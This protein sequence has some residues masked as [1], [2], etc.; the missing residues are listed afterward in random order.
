MNPQEW[1]PISFDDLTG[2]LH[3]FSLFRVL[4][5]AYT[6]NFLFSLY[7]IKFHYHILLK[8]S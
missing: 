6:N 5:K 7:Y 3:F 1:L 4:K 8:F 2:L